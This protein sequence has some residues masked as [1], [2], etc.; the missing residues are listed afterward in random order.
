[1]KAIRHSKNTGEDLGISAEDLLK[2]LAD[3]LLESG[4]NTQ[5]IHIHEW[6]EERLEDF[7]EGIQQSL[8]PG[9]RF[10]G[11]SLQEM[12][13]RLGKMTHEHRPSLIDILIQNTIDEAEQS[14]EAPPNP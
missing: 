9:N 10:D 3:L 1:M 4:F 11:Q 2:E 6:N 12:M 7:K 13:E 5:Y 14:I 8:V